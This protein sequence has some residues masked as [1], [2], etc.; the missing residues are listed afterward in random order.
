MAGGFPSRSDLETTESKCNFEFGENEGTLSDSSFYS[1]VCC[2]S[3]LPHVNKFQHI[4]SKSRRRYVTPCDTLRMAR[5]HGC[6]SW[7]RHIQFLRWV[8]NHR[9]SGRINSKFHSNTSRLEDW[10]YKAERQLA[11]RHGGRNLNG[12]PCGGKLPK[13]H[14]QC[15]PSNWIALSPCWKRNSHR[16]IGTPASESDLKTNDSRSLKVP[17][18]QV[19]SEKKRLVG[20]SDLGSLRVTMALIEQFY[21]ATKARP[22]PTRSANQFS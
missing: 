22:I 12:Y 9:Y 20:S 16:I 18:Y 17:R 21:S 11:L 2:S 13:L 3:N 7:S 6:N 4:S 15:T 14:I 8:R 19:V 10:V 5:N 1:I